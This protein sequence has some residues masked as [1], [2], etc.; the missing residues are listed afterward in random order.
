MPGHRLRDGGRVPGG[1][2]IVA[3]V[4]AVAA[5]GPGW[6]SRRQR[7]KRRDSVLRL[8]G[9]AGLGGVSRQC[10][11]AVDARREA[12]C[13]PPPCAD[14]RGSRRRYE[15][16]PRRAGRSLWEYRPYRRALRSCRAVL[17]TY[18]FG[19]AFEVTDHFSGEVLAQLAAQGNALSQKTQDIGAGESG[20]GMVHPARIEVP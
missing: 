16:W 10:P 15:R 17:D 7:R 13:C 5:V 19:P 9:R 4:Q 8:C 11:G 2:A 3:V 12:L 20:H 18:S 6:W 1:R 14:K